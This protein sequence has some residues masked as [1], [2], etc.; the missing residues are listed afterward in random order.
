VHDWSEIVCARLRRVSLDADRE[1]EIRAE[2]AG[3]LEDAYEDARRRGCSEEDAVARALAAVPD[4]AQLE[5]TIQR[6]NQ[7]GELMSLATKTLW[8]PGMAGLFCAAALVLGVTRLAS[9]ARWADPRPEAQWLAAAI[10][11]SCYVAFGALGA[12]WSRRAGGSVWVR[13]LAGVFP[14]ALHVAMVIT[15][16]AIGMVSEIRWHPQQLRLNFQLGVVLAFVIIPGIALAVGTLP[17]L[18]KGES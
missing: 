17:F 18:R 1:H 14:L 7:E 10:G 9:P 5:R 13:F 16:I 4:W 2:L 11:L 8:A 6:A 12:S 15:A 3:H